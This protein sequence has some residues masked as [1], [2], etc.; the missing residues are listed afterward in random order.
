[1]AAS[2]LAT[3]ADVKTWL[4]GSSGIGTS[5]D[6]LIERLITDVSGAITAY[7][8]RPS[9]TPRTYMERL[10][11]NDKT[12]LFLRHYPV[13]QVISL[14]IDTNSVPAAATAPGAPPARGYLL[15]PW[16]GLP[17][18]RPQALDVFRVFYRKG[19]QNIVVDYTAGY[20]VESEAAG[21]PA[22]PG[23][24]NVSVAVPFRIVGDRRRRHLR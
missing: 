6:V 1:M 21:V 20:A 8:G 23:P 17:P 9:L 7:L 24:Y 3:L 2:D 10:D 12:R 19:R 14:L 11:G 13:L 15:E 18:G 5:D 22:V 4:S 16:D